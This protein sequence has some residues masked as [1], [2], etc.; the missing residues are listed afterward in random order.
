MTARGLHAALA[1]ALLVLPPLLAGC[2]KDR[3]PTRE[4]YQKLRDQMTR[5]EVTEL[6]GAATS[7]QE[8]GYDDETRCVWALTG[9]GEKGTITVVFRE[10]KVMRHSWSQ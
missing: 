7:E 10:G 2:G 4:N 5:D 1:A 6:L 9:D 8:T 3:K